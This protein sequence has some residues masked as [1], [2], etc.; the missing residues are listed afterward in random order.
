MR[1]IAGS[2]GGRVFASPHGHVTHPMSDR[3]RGALFNALGDIT[4]LTVLDAFSGSGALAFEAV[5]RGATKVLAIDND[6]SAQRTIAENIKILGISRQVRLVSSGIGG[7]LSTTSE[8]ELFDIVLCDPPYQDLQLSVITRLNER[9]ATGG[10]LVLSW[11]GKVAAPGFDGF[12]VVLQKN[13]GDAQ[14]IFY[15]VSSL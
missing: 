12:T 7:W 10:T 15:Q 1:I 8:D 5:S 2:L 14:L 13:Y 9:V 4:G 11:P 3:V 6:R